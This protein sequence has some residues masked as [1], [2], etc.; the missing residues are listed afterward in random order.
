MMIA[1]F[2]PF[3]D[4]HK[5]QLIL[6]SLRVEV[7]I[8]INDVDQVL[9]EGHY[10]AKLGLRDH[11]AI[12]S[13]FMH[14]ARSMFKPLESSQARFSVGEIDLLT[15]DAALQL[16]H[17]LLPVNETHGEPDG[18]LQRNYTP[19]TGALILHNA[20]RSTWQAGRYFKVTGGLNVPC[21]AHE[22]AVRSWRLFCDVDVWLGAEAAVVNACRI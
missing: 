20:C 16:R 19:T 5:L 7:R 21:R 4:M 14:I 9:V 8:R 17:Q 18:I 2:L 13:H 15:L 22:M 1:I 10:L 11:H 3:V 12:M 6:P